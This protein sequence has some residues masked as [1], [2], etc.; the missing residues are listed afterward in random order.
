MTFG[1]SVPSENGV[2]DVSELG[3][4]TLDAHS[5]A[6]EP[7]ETFEV[8]GFLPDGRTP[9]DLCDLI[10][11]FALCFSDLKSL[12]MG[13]VLL[14][15]NPPAPPPRE[16]RG[17]GQWSALRETSFRMTCGVIAEML[18]LVQKRRATIGTSQF[19]EIVRKLD[20][21]AREAWSAIENA[22][23]ER[24]TSTTIAG[25]LHVIRNTSA[26]HYDPERIAEGY[27]DFF[28][29][30]GKMPF[31][32][33]GNNMRSTR[34]YFADAAGMAAVARQMEGVSREDLFSLPD[35]IVAQV[36][37]ALSQIVVIFL[38]G[39]GF[40]FRSAEKE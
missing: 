35:G 38:Q 36:N 16:S 27:R 4:K 40:G 37:L 28:V 15:H 25:K 11:A 26:F 13:D 39:R 31:I 12:V 3:M 1:P 24:G 5:A 7:L 33:R 23:Q 2:K 22:A 17:W 29:G 32:S 9:K 8:A 6:L 18:Y 14:E 20:V 34:F 19:R 10:L 21:R 30:T